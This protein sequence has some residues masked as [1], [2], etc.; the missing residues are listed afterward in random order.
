M[1]SNVVKEAVASGSYY[2]EVYVSIPVGPV[3]LEGFIDLTFESDEGLVVVDYKT[4]GVETADEIARSMDR[5]KL[6]GGSYA[7][8]LERATGKVV[9]K[10]I[11][12][13]LHTGSEVVMDDLPKAMDGVQGKIE[14]LVT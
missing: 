4:D 8:A 3:L 2:R 7:L 1:D 12:L 9:S 13:F 6:Q 5:Y 10:V 11:F 14:G